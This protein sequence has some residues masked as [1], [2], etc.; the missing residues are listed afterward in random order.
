MNT[1]N[2]ATHPTALAEIERRILAQ[3]AAGATRISVR[4]TMEAVRRD[5]RVTVNNNDQTAITDDLLRRHPGLPIETRARGVRGKNRPARARTDLAAITDVLGAHGFKLDT[6]TLTG[7]D[8]RRWTLA[9]ATID[10]ALAKVA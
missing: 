5:L 6:I 1:T 3:H 7:P 2:Y 8:G 4:A 10:R 9:P